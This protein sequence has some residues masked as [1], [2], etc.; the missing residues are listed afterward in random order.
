MITAAE[1][2]RYIA[3]LGKPKPKI[4]RAALKRVIGDV[5]RR[6]KSGQGGVSALA[7]RTRMRDGGSDD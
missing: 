4:D 5:E 3:E 2:R 6:S 1:V 7:L